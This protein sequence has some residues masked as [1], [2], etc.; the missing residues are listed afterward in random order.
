MF[1][2]WPE[3]PIVVSYY[4]EDEVDTDT[5]NIIAALNL[6]GSVSKIHFTVTPSSVEWETF[7]AVMQDPFPM[8]EDFTL[9]S[10]WDMMPVISDSFLGGSAPR[11]KYL[12]LKSVPFPKL[13]NLLLSATDLVRL[14]LWVIP[15]PGY[16]S[17]EAMVTC[18]SVL[19]RLKSLS[20][21]FQSPRS[22][23]DRAGKFLPPL[24]RSLLPALIHLEFEGVTEYLEDLVARI[25]VPLLEYTNI[26]F[27]N[28]L[29]FDISQFPNLLRRTEI[30][31]V[32]DQAVI[33]LRGDIISIILSPKVETV[34]FT[35]LELVVSCRKLDWQLSAIAQ[36]CNLCLPTLPRFG[37]PQHLRGSIFITRLARRH[38]K[39]PVAG[40]F[41]SLCRCEGFIPVQGSCATCCICLA[42]ALRGTGDRSVACP[43]RY[44]HR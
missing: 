13:P 12:W 32:L 15:H 41:T 18:I 22:R 26:T 8:L 39:H 10:Y 44:F 2:I 33:R 7:A 11:L 3:L 24:T 9:W 4:G 19:T 21:A 30:F 43:A 37:T 42:R 25:D 1:N 34:G 20:L 31:T 38:G 29:V 40:T 27:F 28:H 5:D 17:P 6:K 36:V 35:R 16:I 23:P 14:N